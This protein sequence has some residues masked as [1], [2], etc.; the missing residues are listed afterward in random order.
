MVAEAASH[1][2][3]KHSKMARIGSTI[4]AE[5]HDKARA[6]RKQT[7]GMDRNDLQVIAQSP[8]QSESLLAF[9]N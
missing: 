5:S 6:A 3:A 4:I 7:K 1:S 2:W 8:F 9:I